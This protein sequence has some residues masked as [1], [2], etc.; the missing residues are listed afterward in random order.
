MY[1]KMIKKEVPFKQIA[2]ISGKTA[3]IVRLNQITKEPYMVQLN[4][5]VWQDFYKSATRNTDS[6]KEAGL[7]HAEI[8]FLSKNIIKGEKRKPNKNK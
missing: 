3:I 7:T 6:L 1:A 4:A 2:I 5:D 8:L